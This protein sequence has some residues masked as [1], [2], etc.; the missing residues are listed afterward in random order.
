MT[1]F[2]DIQFKPHPH[3]LGIQ[4]S[5]TLKKFK[6]EILLSVVAGQGLYSLPREKHLSPDDFQKFEIAL[7]DEGGFCTQ[8]FIEDAG[9]DVIGWQTRDDIN[10]IIKLILNK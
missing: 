4:G 1:N 5:L 8:D 10:N 3:G 9:D 6:K 2:N 7:L